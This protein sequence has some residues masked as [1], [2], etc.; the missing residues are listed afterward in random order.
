MFW[1]RL[2]PSNHHGIPLRSSLSNH[3]EI[4]LSSSLVHAPNVMTNSHTKRISYPCSCVNCSE[5]I[6]YSNG[7]KR[8]SAP[9]DSISYRCQLFWTTSHQQPCFYTHLYDHVSV[10]A[11]PS[12]LVYQQ[13]SARPREQTQVIIE[14]KHRTSELIRIHFGNDGFIRIDFLPRQKQR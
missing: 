3:Y 6:K 2:S 11:S 5:H 1:K 7:C 9:S 10:P 4:S 12:L 13:L 8:P 14:R